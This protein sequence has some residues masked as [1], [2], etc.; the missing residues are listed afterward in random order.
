MCTL[1]DNLVVSLVNDKG[2][3]SGHGAGG[4]YK[5][6]DLHA[7]VGATAGNM[8]SVTNPTSRLMMGVT[9]KRQTSF[10]GMRVRV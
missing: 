1:N 6:M 10:R 3:S 4:N 7:R 9:N 2:I 8:S 5:F